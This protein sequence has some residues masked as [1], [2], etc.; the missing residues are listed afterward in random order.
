MSTTLGFSPRMHGLMGESVRVA[1]I[2][3]GSGDFMFVEPVMMDEVQ[4]DKLMLG[5]NREY[6]K[7]FS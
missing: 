7:L 1:C 4:V 3:G 6:S 2:T 5:S